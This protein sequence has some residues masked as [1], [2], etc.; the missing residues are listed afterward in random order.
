MPY[1]LQNY[2]IDGTWNHHQSI[3][4]DVIL[5][6]IFYIAYREFKSPPRSWRSKKAIEV[7]GKFS[8][9]AVNPASISY[10][11]LSLNVENQ[12]CPTFRR[13]FLKTPP[14]FWGKLRK[15]RLFSVHAETASK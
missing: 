12:T 11:N 8:G 1:K 7:V 3:I 9:G 10:M 2:E 5:D 6:R 4:L 15:A 13:T 14:S